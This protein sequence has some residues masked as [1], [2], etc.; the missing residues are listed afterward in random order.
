MPN[1]RAIEARTY[2]SEATDRKGS[3]V[4]ESQPSLALF[5]SPVVVG[6]VVSYNDAKWSVF[7]SRGSSRTSPPSS[8]SFYAGK[9]VAEDT[10]TIRL[11]ETVGYIVVGALHDT[12]DGIQYEAGVTADVVRGVDNSPSYSVNYNQVFPNP[13]AVTI[14]S[15]VAMDG[16]DGGWHS[17]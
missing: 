3:W 11:D 12:V 17:R 8:T 2:V 6:K 7:W 14:V 16:G 10:V 15:Q 4:G 1:G 13:P 5:D 9:H